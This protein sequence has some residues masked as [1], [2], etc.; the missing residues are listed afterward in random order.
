M[1]NWS[2]NQPLEAATPVPKV[3]T[4]LLALLCEPSYS[5]A[6]SLKLV[7]VFAVV[8]SEIPLLLFDI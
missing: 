3:K 5:A 1:C 7:G 6:V 2:T 8:A 4:P